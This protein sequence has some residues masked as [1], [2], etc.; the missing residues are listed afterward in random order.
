MRLYRHFALIVGVALA[1]CAPV[2]ITQT[3]VVPQTVQVPQTVRVPETVQV[4]VTVEVEVTRIAE[5]EVTRLVER[6]VTAT[7]TPTPINSPTITPTPTNAQPPTRTFTPTRTPN[8]AQTSTARAL[9]RLQ[10]DFGEGFQLV[11]VDIAPGLWRSNGSQTNCYWARTD[12]NNNILD[13]HFGL[14]GGTVNIRASDFQFESRK[15]GSWTYI[16]AP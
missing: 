6:V 11:G 1:A 13:N 2:E 3:V 4:E 10:R 15:C 16:G 5:V 14:A 9:A 7:F 12:R 8:V